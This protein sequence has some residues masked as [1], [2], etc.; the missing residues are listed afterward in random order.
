[1]VCLLFVSGQLLVEVGWVA[2][3]GNLEPAADKASRGRFTTCNNSRFLA[4]TTLVN[5]TAAT[6]K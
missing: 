6:R 3:G 2:L 4:P 5:E 1:M